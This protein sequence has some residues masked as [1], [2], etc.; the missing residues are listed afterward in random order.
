MEWRQPPTGDTTT[1]LTG[2]GAPCSAA[3]A[4]RSF[5]FTVLFT[6]GTRT[7]GPV[8]P[9]R[10]PMAARSMSPNRWCTNTAMRRIAHMTVAS[11]GRPASGSRPGPSWRGTPLG[12]SGGKVKWTVP[13]DAARPR[14]S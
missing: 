7:S 8:A 6:G 9:K 1:Q 5:I 3:Y 14:S 2:G 10:S 4:A 11:D 12:P 13:S